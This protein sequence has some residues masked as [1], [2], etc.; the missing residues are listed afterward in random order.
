M[1][2][3]VWSGNR[4]AVL[5]LPDE[6]P[7][8]S[9]QNNGDAADLGIAGTARVA[10]EVTA[11]GTTNQVSNSS[12]ELKKEGTRLFVIGANTRSAWKGRC[13]LLHVGVCRDE[14]SIGMAWPK[15]SGGL[16]FGVTTKHPSGVPIVSG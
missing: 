8:S 2:L 14:V 16:C 3:S 1:K 4:Y 12:S 6:D 9:G 11:T 7:P 15:F 10:V 5:Y 13:L